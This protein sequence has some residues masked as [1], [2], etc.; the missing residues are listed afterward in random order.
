MTERGSWKVDD[1]T[2]ELV[3]VEPII[4]QAEKE[5]ARLKELEHFKELSRRR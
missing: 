3:K 2:G 5:A 1:K 4:S